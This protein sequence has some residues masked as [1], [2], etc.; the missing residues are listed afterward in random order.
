MIFLK[1]NECN[2]SS[3]RPDSGEKWTTLFPYTYAF[4][5]EACAFSRQRDPL[6]D[7]IG[8]GQRATNS[9]YQKRDQ[10]IEQTLGPDDI[11]FNNLLI[12]ITW[13]YVFCF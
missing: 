11:A 8:S 3:I 9:I 7:Q 10:K 5:L 1:Y 4:W 13:F 2:I 6:L 12:I